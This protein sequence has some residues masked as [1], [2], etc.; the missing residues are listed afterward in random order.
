MAEQWYYARGNEKFGP[1]SSTQLKALA[2]HGRLLPT[3]ML[4]KEGMP[5]W[6]PA[7][8]IK[9]L[10]AAS[11]PPQ[12]PSLPPWPPAVPIVTSRPVPPL[13]THNSD[14]YKG[15]IAKKTRKGLIIGL[16]L[17]GGSVLIALVAWIIF[18]NW[19]GG[20]GTG[21]TAK[22]EIGQEVSKRTDSDGGG[23]S[24]PEVEPI[25]L[26]K[27]IIGTW[28][29]GAKTQDAADVIWE[30]KADGTI[31]EERV[32]KTSNKIRQDGKCSLGDA[33]S[34]GRDSRD[35]E[36]RTL[37]IDL[38][39]QY[40]LKFTVKMSGG[41][42]LLFSQRTGDVET[43]TRVVALTPLPAQTRAAWED[44]D[45]RSEWMT[46]GAFMISSERGYAYADLQFEASDSAIIKLPSFR[47]VNWQANAIARL[48]APDQPFGLELSNCEVTDLGLKE[49]TGLKHLRALHL[50]NTKITGAGLKALAGL[51]QLQALDLYMTKVTDVDLKELTGLRLD[52]FRFPPAAQ[53]DLGLKNSIGAINPPKTLDLD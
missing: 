51:K 32:G 39:G 14:E 4:H 34:A 29:R 33:V 11:R 19:G 6:M 31:T 44:A 30:F 10:F 42:L 48:P 2:A 3:D 53:T 37:A 18:L 47:C 7:M 27:K 16:S 40:D 52:Y 9:G 25:D 45:F 26:A 20:G 1:F 49:L 28:Q 12:P 50:C 36:R 43:W 38:F 15:G 22:E 35:H 23:S 8:R 24:S 13:P 17:G 21:G 46:L 41:E 5:K